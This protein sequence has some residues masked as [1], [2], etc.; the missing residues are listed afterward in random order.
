MVA[1][2]DWS[3]WWGR[4]KKLLRA[5][6]FYRIQDAA[7]FAVERLKQAVSYEEDLLKAFQKSDWSGRRSLAKKVFRERGKVHPRLHEVITA[8]LQRVV[9]EAIGPQAIEAAILLEKFNLGAPIANSSIL[10]CAL[11]TCSDPQKMVCKIEGGE[12]QRMAMAVLPQVVKEKWPE[13]A[14]A[15]LTAGSD[16]IRDSICELSR[17]EP[18][19]D[20]IASRI[21]EVVRGPRMAPDLFVWAARKS[22]DGAQDEIFAAVSELTPVELLERILDLLDHLARKGEREGKELTKEA[23]ARARSLIGARSHDL[24]RRVLKDLDRVK[25]RSLYERILI[26]S[27]LSEALRIEAL[28]IITR[29]MPEV[30]RPQDVPV[31]E[32]NTI[33]VTEAGLKKRHEE[34]REIMEVKLPENFR[35]IGRAASFGDLSENAEYSAALESR[36]FLTKK[37]TEIRAELNRARLITRSM[38]KEGEVTLGSKVTFLNIQ[39]GKNQVYRI[40]GPWDGNPD[41]GVISYR[42]PIGRMFLGLKI[43]DEVNVQLPSGKENYRILSIEPGI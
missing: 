23:L 12:E 7:P 10:L 9:R 39:T 42:S 19:R 13:A 40:L 30:T 16:S 2:D 4:A 27:G 43:N 33:Y 25:G 20:R 1:S 22:I 8:D 41:D 36:D 38:L 11:Q 18:W 3:K 24:L 37:A 35:D 15:L 31:W 6:G 17:K 14:L 32:E 29:T 5:S 26:S 21:A 34:L 28:D